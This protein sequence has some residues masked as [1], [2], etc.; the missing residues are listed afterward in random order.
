MMW[1]GGGNGQ[2]MIASDKK[3]FLPLRVTDA[4]RACDDRSIR[5]CGTVGL[6][7]VGMRIWILMLMLMLM[8]MILMGG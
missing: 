1:V 3:G 7:Q 8:L 5:V 4:R 2:T 6:I